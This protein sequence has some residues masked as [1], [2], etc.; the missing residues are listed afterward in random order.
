MLVSLVTF[1]HSL[2]KYYASY[3]GSSVTRESHS[4]NTFWR[5][6]PEPKPVGNTLVF[7]LPVFF[8]PPK[9]LTTLKATVHMEMKTLSSYSLFSF[10]MFQ[11]CVNFFLLWNTRTQKLY[12]PTKWAKDAF[13]LVH[14]AFQNFIF[15]VNRYNLS[16]VVAMIPL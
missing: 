8:A 5:N 11:T 13:N 10:T 9:F 4:H 7:F 12:F 1:T 15:S 14:H 3:Y 16:Y 6:A 2:H